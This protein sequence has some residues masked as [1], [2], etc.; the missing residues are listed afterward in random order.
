MEFSASRIPALDGIRGIAILIVIV[1]HF[2]ILQG[3]NFGVD[4]F[5]V[6]SGFL[7]TSILLQEQRK[8]GR[9]SISKFYLRR[10]LRLLPA[11]FF[12]VIC[13]LIYTFMMQPYS[14]FLLALSDAW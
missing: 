14:R 2:G 9:V 10:A 4:L 3:G 5:F 8:N 13:V 12:L 11:L 1:A 7:I 6:L